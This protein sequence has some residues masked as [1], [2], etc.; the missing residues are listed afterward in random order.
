MGLPCAMVTHL[1]Q[2]W[3]KVLDSLAWAS[4]SPLWDD[5]RAND[6]HFPTCQQV[7]NNKQKHVTWHQE[8]NLFCW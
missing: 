4:S 6:S 8:V 2:V 7:C 3:E 1:T 5:I